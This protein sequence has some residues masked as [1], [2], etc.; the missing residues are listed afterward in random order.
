MANFFQKVLR[1]A[2]KFGHKIEMHYEGSTRYTT[3]FG[4]F[5]TIVYYILIAINA[6]NIC[7]DFLNNEN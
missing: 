3:G 4:G 5:I 6:V 1:S 7:T 2:D